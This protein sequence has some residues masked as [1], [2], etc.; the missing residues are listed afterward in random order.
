MRQARLVADGEGRIVA[1]FGDRQV[2]MRAP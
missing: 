1:H 2:V